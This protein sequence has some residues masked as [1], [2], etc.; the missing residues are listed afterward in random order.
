MDHSVVRATVE[1]DRRP[2]PS[3]TISGDLA[4]SSQSSSYAM[5]YRV[6][7]WLEEQVRRSTMV[8]HVDRVTRTIW[9]DCNSDDQAVRTAT[10]LLERVATFVNGEGQKWRMG[11]R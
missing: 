11:D 10:A 8:V 9:I 5:L 2:R 6:A 7:A 1:V 3:L 4:L